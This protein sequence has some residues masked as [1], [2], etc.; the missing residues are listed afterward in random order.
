MNIEDEIHN[1]MLELEGKDKIL[2][3]QTDLLYLLHN[4]VYPDIKEFAKYCGDCR[5]RVYNRVR[6]YWLANIKNKR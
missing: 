1:L 3:H 4:I 5:A 2:A 6:E